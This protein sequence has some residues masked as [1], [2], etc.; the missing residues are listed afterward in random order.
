[1]WWYAPVIPATQEAVGRRIFAGPR[2]KYE[3]LC[4]KYSKKGLEVWLK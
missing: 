3:T 2:Q 1:M 4:E